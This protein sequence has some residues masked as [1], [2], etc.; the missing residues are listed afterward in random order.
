MHKLNKHSQDPQIVGYSS[1]VL[2]TFLTLSHF[3]VRL[4]LYLRDGHP[5]L[6]PSIAPH[7]IPGSVPSC[8]LELQRNWNEAEL[9]QGL[10]VR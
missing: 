6:H 2:R 8:V 4:D 3:L 7:N 1:T 9:L 5:V 10:P